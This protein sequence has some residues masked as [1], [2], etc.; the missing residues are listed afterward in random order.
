MPCASG[1]AKIGTMSDPAR[2][3]PLA[4]PGIG[5]VVAGR[6]RIDQALGVGGMAEVF[7]AFDLEASLNVALK[8]LL[9]EIAAKPE[10]VE[11]TKREGKVLSEL[12][13]PAIV[14]V[15]RFGELDDGTVF[16]V[17]ELLEGETLGERMRRGVFD[18]AELAPIVTGT[19]AG[20]HAAH[21]RAIVHRDLKPDNIFLCPTLYGLQ[22]KLLDFGIS[23]VYGQKRL[24][25]TGQVLGTPRYMSP[26]QLSGEPDIDARV[27]V[28]SLG[29]ILYE[30]LAGKP[31]FMAQTPTELIIAILHGKVAPLGSVRRD[32]PAAVEAVVMRAM[33]KVRTARFDTAMSLGEAYIDAIGGPAAVRGEQHR[34]MATRNMGEAGPVSSV[35]PPSEPNVPNT[36]PPPAQPAQ[37]DEARNLRLGTFSSLAESPRAVD[38]PPKK[39]KETVLMGASSGAPVPQSPGDPVAAR[40]EQDDSW[41]AFARTEEV[42]KVSLPVS[43]PRVL[44]QTRESP[45]VVLDPEPPR[46]LK[47]APMSASQPAK[48]RA[49]DP[50]RLAPLPRRSTARTVIL[51]LGALLAGAASA[52]L[53]ITAL[54]FYDR[55]NTTREERRPTRLAPAPA[56]RTVEPAPATRTVEPPPPMSPIVDPPAA[57]PSTPSAQPAALPE[58]A[59]RPRR[60]AR[61]D[62]GVVLPPPL[63]LP[64]FGEPEPTRT[65]SETIRDARRALREGDPQRCVDLLNEVIGRGP[66]LALRQRGDCLEALGRREEAIADYRRFCQLGP[67]HPAISEVR[68]ILESWGESCP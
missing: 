3:N 7:R 33:S 67:D 1:D 16:L 9:P 13:N 49:P 12:S 17:M 20:L 32:V 40:P 45:A 35:P 51:V 54:Y 15:S 10:A 44:P 52:A 37:S 4:R 25:H 21:S 59:T 34:G 57:P 38:S 11:R 48:V 14:S 18:P 68:P 22:V 43:A 55:N 47:T 53:V 26:E 19:C 36:R 63:T 29:V 66:A 41:V 58:K 50:P 31:P 28:Y 23:K 65:P 5:S 42:P 8:I 6:Y 39:I 27:D 2:R 64:G 56:T 60:P 61:A 24:T 30:A 62:E 46:V